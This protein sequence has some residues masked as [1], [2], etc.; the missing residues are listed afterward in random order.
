[1][2]Q[3]KNAPKN[4][5]KWFNLYKTCKE[6]FDNFNNSRCI[7]FLKMSKELLYKGKNSFHFIILLFECQIFLSATPYYHRRTIMSIKTF[8]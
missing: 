5:G 7:K 4:R 2:K 3:L 1:M 8:S 6:V